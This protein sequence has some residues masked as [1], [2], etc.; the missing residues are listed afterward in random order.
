[1]FLVLDIGNTNQKAA[2]FTA[3]GKEETVLR[4][5][6]LAVEHL[7]NLFSRYRIDAALLSAV[8]SVEEDVV[9]WLEK[10]T[11]LVCFN[12]TLKLP[13]ALDY[14]TPETLGT[15]RIASAVGAWALFP[16]EN[17]LVIQAGTCLVTDFVDAQGVYRGGSI[18]PGLRLRFRALH[19]HTAHLPLLEPSS[20]D[21]LTGKSTQESILSGVIQG[22]SCEIDGIIHHYKTLFPNIN[23]ILTGGDADFLKSMIK[24]RIFAA[25]NLVLQ[26]LYEILRNNVE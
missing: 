7:E 1:M 18:A 22:I 13:V 3:D 11:R 15:D 21:F 2:V 16:G 19:D 8:G 9:D 4:Y 24:N 26:G 12:S 23:I 5:D 14:K 17:T 20:I 6:K 10:N 25:P